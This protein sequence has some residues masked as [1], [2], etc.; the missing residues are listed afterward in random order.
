[1]SFPWN[2]STE[3]A[4]REVFAENQKLQ[5]LTR[6]W[7]VYCL[8]FMQKEAL[9]LQERLSEKQDQIA[10]L[11]EHLVELEQGSPMP[12]EPA[13]PETATGL[14]EVDKASA[15]STLLEVYTAVAS[16]D[17]DSDDDLSNFTMQIHMKDRR[18]EMESDGNYQ[19]MTASPQEPGFVIFVKTPIGKTITLN[20]Q[21][22]DIIEKIVV[23]A[24]RAI[25]ADRPAS[26]L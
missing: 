23:E 4:L 25:D 14:P 20:I 8:G 24:A 9:Q 18:I 16:A 15:A 21:E 1:M 6:R 5:S 7:L 19:I 11:H 22:T 17:P 3:T 13:V 26:A 12:S 10:L 2:P